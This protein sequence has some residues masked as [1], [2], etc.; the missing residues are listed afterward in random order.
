MQI[1]NYTQATK[2]LD[3][4]LVFGIKPGLARINKILEL[5]G[6][7]HKKT[8]F[9]HVVGTNGKTSTAIIASHIIY[10]HGIKCGYHISPHINEYNE[11]LWVCGANISRSRFARLFSD[12]YPYVQAVND[13]NLDGPMTQFEIIAA[14]AFRLAADEHLKVMVLEAGMGGRWDAT[15]AADSTVVGLTG[16]SLEHTAILGDNIAAIAAEKAQVIKK[17]AYVATTSNEVTVLEVLRRITEKTDSK[18]LVLGRD[19][20]ILKKEKIDLSGWEVD[21]KVV[22][23][24]YRRLKIPLIGNYQPA[25]LSLALTLVE[26]YLKKIGK[27]V[28][29]TLVKKALPGIKVPGR[30]T[31]IQRNP[32]V[33]ADTSH[34]PEGIKNFINNLDENFSSLRKIIIFAVLKDKN[35]KEMVADIL[36]AS[37]ILILTSSQ[38][39]RSLDIEILESE[40][41]CCL[42]KPVKNK[43]NRLP[44]KVYKIDNIGN[45]LNFALNI[46][47]SNDIICITGSITNLEHINF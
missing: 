13:L 8:D 35:Y 21:L 18:L 19:F 46:S 39:K 22:K 32:L 41:A 23:S 11:R 14:M 1:F 3:D 33:I 31:V 6:N 17:G 47:K 45:S 30:F 42:E 36:P 15:N 5:Q 10:K 24:E 20:F 2:Y 16:V 34:N 44:G 4:C 43:T 38:T 29:E 40:V 28:D 9:I 26:L 7:T 27:K 25:N 12:I 37:D